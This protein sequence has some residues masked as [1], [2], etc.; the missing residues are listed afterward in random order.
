M[1]L[2]VDAAAARKGSAY[3]ILSERQLSKV[4]KLRAKTSADLARASAPLRLCGSGLGVQGSGC[5]AGFLP[6]GAGLWA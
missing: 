4:V 5:R 2:R 6:L 3:H 1:E